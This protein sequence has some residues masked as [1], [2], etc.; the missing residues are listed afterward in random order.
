MRV[1]RSVSAHVSGEREKEDQNDE[2]A[3][4]SGERLSA[5]SQLESPANTW[6][7]HF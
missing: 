1:F 5:Q 6:L 7:V 3:Q 2:S 4:V